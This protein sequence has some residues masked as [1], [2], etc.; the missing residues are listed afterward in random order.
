MPTK[1]L[2][3]PRSQ[4]GVLHHQLLSCCLMTGRTTPV[5][6]KAGISHLAC[7]QLSFPWAPC[8]PCVCTSA[9][10][11]LASSLCS[12]VTPSSFWVWDLFYT[13]SFPVSCFL[14]TSKRYVSVLVLLDSTLQGRWLLGRAA[15]FVWFLTD[16]SFRDFLFLTFFWCPFHTSI[17]PPKVDL[18]LATA[19][20]VPSSPCS[21]WDFFNER[22]LAPR[23]PFLVNFHWRPTA[24]PVVLC[25]LASRWVLLVGAS[26]NRWKGSARRLPPSMTGLLSKG[27]PVT[28]SPLLPP[29]RCPCLLLWILP[30]PMC[31]LN[32]ALPLWAILHEHLCISMTWGN[33][34]ACLGPY[35]QIWLATKG[36]QEDSYHPHLYKRDSYSIW[37]KDEIY[38]NKTVFANTWL[39]PHCYKQGW[40]FI[41]VRWRVQLNWEGPG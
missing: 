5:L 36:Y 34:H 28:L 4:S 19:L 11:S 31:S 20:A 26:R 41:R 9:A 10:T 27:A 40:V 2:S 22:S 33:F 16:F 32:A 7:A 35:R 29:L 6:D 23:W 8:C 37:W 21:V 12:S 3:L 14:A 15:L 1:H 24:F 17:G 38:K 13:A 30:T 39:F 18:V 25:L